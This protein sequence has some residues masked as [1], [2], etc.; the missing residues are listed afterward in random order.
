[1]KKAIVIFVT[2]LLAGYVVYA[3]I[4]F[5]SKPTESY[6]KEIQITIKDTASGQFILSQDV[7][8]FLERNKIF[9]VGK[10]I[11]NINSEEIEQKLREIPIIGEVE[12]YF[13]PGGTLF[14]T[15]S[16]RKPIL[17]ILSNLD[18]YY[19]DDEAKI[20]PSSSNFSLH[21]PIATG[22]IDTLYAQNNLY[23]FA[24]FL[25]END[26]WNAQIAQIDVLANKDVV[27]IPRIGE[28]QILLGQ[29]DG[30]EEKLERLMKFYQ[31]GLSETGWNKYDKI[32]LKFE[33][34]V[35]CTKRSS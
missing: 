32:N 17:R 27:L 5:E 35:V 20:I 10:K 19:M 30:F 14:I 16:Q 11:A 29:L 33:N 7:S 25:K 12:C 4:T 6:C 18:N 9:P 34:Q 26:F 15:I 2:I 8:T 31:N 13:S 21:L 22:N 3:I 28:H 23:K 1:M 24:L